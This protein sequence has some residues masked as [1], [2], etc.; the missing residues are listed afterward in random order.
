MEVMDDEEGGKRRRKGEGYEMLGDHLSGEER[1][2]KE[3]RERGRELQ[4]G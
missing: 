3:G 1:G 4:G 2:R